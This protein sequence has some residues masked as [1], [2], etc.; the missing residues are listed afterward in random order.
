MLVSSK[1]LQ[2]CE[3]DWLGYS[4]VFC[5]VCVRPERIKLWK[6]WKGHRY[7]RY[8][9]TWQCIVMMSRH[10]SEGSLRSKAV[11]TLQL[12]LRKM[13]EKTAPTCMRWKDCHLIVWIIRHWKM[14]LYTSLTATN[15]SSSGEVYAGPYQTRDERASNTAWCGD[16][17]SHANLSGSEKPIRGSVTRCNFKRVTICHDAALSSWS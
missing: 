4:R 3:G 5:H 1:L 8:Q 9:F 6:P 15:E 11:G 10:N 13:S 16:L 7:H 14:H 2:C 12:L 17:K